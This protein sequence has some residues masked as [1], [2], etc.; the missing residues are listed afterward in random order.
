MKTD[1]QLVEIAQRHAEADYERNDAMK[2]P[3][4]GWR[5]HRWVIDAMREAASTPLTTYQRDASRT[6]HNPMLPIVPGALTSDPVFK[7]NVAV[8]AMG[9]AGEAG[10]VADYLKKV[11]GHGK[12][13]DVDV[14]KKELGDVLWY[15]AALATMYGFTLEEVA[16]LNTEKLLKRF[17]SGFTE[18]DAETRVDVVKP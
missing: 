5:R 4:A 6:L 17:P 1:A 7:M 16:K 11:L 2:S 18:A 12:A 10:E 8:F 15:M 9:L 14:L 13:F 3:P